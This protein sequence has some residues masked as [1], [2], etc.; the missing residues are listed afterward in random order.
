M[1]GAY[2]RRKG[3]SWEGETVRFMRE[4]DSTSRR[5]TAETQN[6]DEN[7]GVDVLV[8][9]LPLA[10]QCKNA[11]VWKGWSALEE[12]A[13]E[14]KIA[15]GFIKQS[16]RGSRDKRECVVLSLEGFHK[17][18]SLAFLPEQRKNEDDRSKSEA[19]RRKCDFSR[20]SRKKLSD[21]RPR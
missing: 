17:L 4:F 3:I 20:R 12:A 11:G 15:V 6:L 8:D 19:P 10:I 7:Q 16:S 9:N 5:N 14:G 13:R 21:S 2:S 1:G 18:M